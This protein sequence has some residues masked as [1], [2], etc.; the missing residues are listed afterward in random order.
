MNFDKI[1]AVG[2]VLVIASFEEYSRI[3]TTS[4]PYTGDG[5]STCIYVG[6]SWRISGAV[7]HCD[8]LA[9]GRQ[10]T[11]LLEMPATE[12]VDVCT[13]SHMHQGGHSIFIIWYNFEQKY[14]LNKNIND[15]IVPSL[16]PAP[17]TWVFH[18]F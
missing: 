18:Q 15:L 10:A 6:L 11:W 3:I 12:I 8:D 17:K 5:T 1:T 4:Q 16:H 2:P 7:L 9:R 14:L 13:R